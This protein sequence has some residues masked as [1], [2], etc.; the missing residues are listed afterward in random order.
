MNDCP[1]CGKEND[2]ELIMIADFIIDE[3]TRKPYTM[4]RYQ[5]INCNNEF[6]QELKRWES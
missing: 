2:I 6:N 1:T 4:H 3:E 5:Y